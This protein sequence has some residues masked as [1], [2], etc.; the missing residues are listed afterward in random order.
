MTMHENCLVESI[1]IVD[2]AAAE[3][4]LCRGIDFSPKADMRSWKRGE[5]VTYKT[6]TFECGRSRANCVNVRWD[7]KGSWGKPAFS[8]VGR[9]LRNMPVGPSALPGITGAGPAVEHPQRAGRPLSWSLRPTVGGAL[10]SGPV[11]Q[12]HE[13][14]VI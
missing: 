11:A 13:E 9:C 12:R 8:W 7:S 2:D 5:P 6:D 10:P 1:S 3:E 4:L 14:P